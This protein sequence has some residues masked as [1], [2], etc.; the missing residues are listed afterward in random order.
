MFLLLQE[1]SLDS[2]NSRAETT[3]SKRKKSATNQKLDLP[4]S[5]LITF[6]RTDFLVT[7]TKD[8][9]EISAVLKSYE[10]ALNHGS[11]DEALSLYAPDVS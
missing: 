1:L 3:R 5:P 9:E 4:H 6:W 7:V 2:I 11:T 10:Q 8:S